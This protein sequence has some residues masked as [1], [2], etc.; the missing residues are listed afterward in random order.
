MKRRPP[1]LD[2][3]LAFV[4]APLGARLTR[5]ACGARHM[6]AGT[7]WEPG[8][9]K[10]K[11]WSQ[12]CAKCGL[13]EE[14]ARGRTP[15]HWPNGAPVLETRLVPVGALLRSQPCRRKATAARTFA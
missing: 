11:V 4:C 10:V 5:A 1:V 14:H 7:P 2:A 9:R 8:A 6:N 15:R 13:G 3:T 12:E